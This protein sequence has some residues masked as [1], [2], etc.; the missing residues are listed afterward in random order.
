ML[1]QAAKALKGKLK[2]TKN[3]MASPSPK[4]KGAVLAEGWAEKMS[5]S[6]GKKYWVNEVRLL[7]RSCRAPPNQGALTPAP[8]SSPLP[9]ETSETTWE[10]PVEAPPKKKGRKAESSSESEEEQPKK[11]GK[12][13]KAES[14]SESESEEEKPKKK[15]K[16]KK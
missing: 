2:S 14:S 10:M 7:A 15:G 1:A 16:G 11:K 12:G 8:P 9:Q 6:T 4:K 5:K 13:R 3:P